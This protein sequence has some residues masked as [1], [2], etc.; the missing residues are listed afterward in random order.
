MGKRCSLYMKDKEWSE[1]VN[2]NRDWYEGKAEFTELENTFIKHLRKNIKK[3][4]KVL[5]IA[6]GH[7]KWFG[8]IKDITTDYLG[9]DFCKE[10]IEIARKKYPEGKFK[11]VDMR[12]L[13]PLKEYDVIFEVQSINYFDMT[14]EQFIKKFKKFAKKIIIYEPGGI[15]IY[16]N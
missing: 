8:I 13:K 12:G 7:G 5:D 15:R 1:I 3:D 10:M 14:Q 4:D 11:L 6:C 2:N 9:I 16:E